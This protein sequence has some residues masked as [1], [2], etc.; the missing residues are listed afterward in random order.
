MNMGVPAY[1][2]AASVQL[3]IAQRLARRLCPKCKKPS[4]LPQ[5][6]LLELGFDEAELAE[7]QIYDAVGCS[8]CTKGY[9]GRVGI[10][11]VVKV[12]PEL[13][14]L[15]MHS[16]SA[17]EISRKARDQGFPDLRQSGRR[18]VLSGLTSVDELTRVTM[19]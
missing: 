19:E 6:T 1:N 9:K 10:Y 18:K 8:Q 17:M 2:L 16:A 14:D 13:A 12:T 7:K 15:V 11:E 5:D 4:E 3:I